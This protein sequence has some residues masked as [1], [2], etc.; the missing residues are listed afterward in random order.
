MPDGQQGARRANLI[1]TINSV[2]TLYNWIV[3][4]ILIL[5]LFLIGRF[6]EIKFGQKSRYQLML[7][8]PVLFLVAAVLYAVASDDIVGAPVPDILFLV[9]GLILIWLCYSLYKTMMGGRR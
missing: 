6:Y 7:L 1:L 2:L 9:G 3:V 4:T 5:F 8:P